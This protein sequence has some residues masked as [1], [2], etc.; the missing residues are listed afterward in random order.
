MRK[1]TLKG[2]L[3]EA[4]IKK[5][6]KKAGFFEF[7]S[8]ELTRSKRFHGRGA[9]HQIDIWGEFCF[10]IPFIYP[11]NL[12][13]EAKA[14]KKQVGLGTAR[15]FVGV[16]KDV[17][18]VY[19]IDTTK[20]GISRYSRV[21]KT[22]HTH[23][24]VI[25]SLNG[26]SKN[27]EEYMY[28]QGIYPITYEN[29]SEIIKI[30]RKFSGLVNSIEVRNLKVSDKK[31][32]KNLD[33]LPKISEDAKKKE[34]NRKYNKLISYLGSINSYLGML[35]GKYIVNI[36][37]KKDFT[38][39]NPSLIYNLD[40]SKRFI[41]KGKRSNLGEFSLSKQFIKYYL[42]D[43]NNFSKVFSYMDIFILDKE[44][45]FIAKLKFSEN[46]INEIMQKIL[47]KEN[48]TQNTTSNTK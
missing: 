37:T 12:L 22:R 17:S 8:E 15:N 1:E 6:V 19:S 11:L 20:G 18:E 43:K 2:R 3:F 42:A 10:T 36:I 48:E 23:C 34:F 13:G 31:Y 26:F 24:P 25:F 38:K 47:P 9:T 29:N 4:L 32:F 14:Y 27:A 46:S 33:N 21:G 16:V 44:K 5:L 41:I 7:S 39:I 30:Y 35:G 45:G 40:Y 28:A